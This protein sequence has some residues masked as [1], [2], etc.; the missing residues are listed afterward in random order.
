MT[1]YPAIML[2]ATKGIE[3]V[4][5]AIPEA[6]IQ[7]ISIL[8]TDPSGLTSVN[9]LGIFS[10]ISVAGLIYSDLC[11]ELTRSQMSAGPYHPLYST[12]PA[13]KRNFI[14]MW[15]G[16]FTFTIFYFVSNVFAITLAYLKFRGHAIFNAMVLELALVMIYKH[17]VDGQLLAFGILSKPSKLD[18]I[19][20]PLLTFCFY[21]SSFVGRFPH[22]RNP[23]EL[24]PHVTSALMLWRMIT[25]FI[26]V[27]LLL[28]SLVKEGVVKAM[29]TNS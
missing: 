26:V 1:F 16:F 3:I 21:I 12:C 17:F 4:C 9:Y 27:M 8:S 19:L 10:S 28:P 23:T 25:S 20:G 2:A 15:S 22:S 5:E 29:D 6:I 11:L 24:G 14:K 7:A 18:Y 13:N